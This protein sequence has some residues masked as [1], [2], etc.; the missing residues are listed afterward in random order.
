MDPISTPIKRFDFDDKISG[1]A[2]YCADIRS[3]NLLFAKT[4]RSTRPRA[5]ILS[6][7][8]PPLPDGYCIVDANDI[9]GRN[10][11]PIVQDDQPF[12]ASQR[13]NYIGEPI[14][15]VVGPDKQVIVDL[16]D[17]MSVTYED[18]RPVLSIDEAEQVRDD[19]LFGG[20]PCFVSYEFTKGDVA[21]AASQAERV[22]EDEFSTGYQEH[23][24]LETQGCC[25]VYENGRVTVSGSMQCPY[26]I[27]EAL[28]QALGWPEERVRV[29]QLPTGGGFGGKEEYPSIPAV[30]AALAAIKTNH[31]VQ[32][33]FDRHEDM[34]CTTKRHP[35]RIRIRS[36]VDGTKRVIGRE[37]TV[38]TDA[39]AYAGLSSVVLQRLMFSSGGVYDVPHL[40]VTGAAYATNNIVS[41]AFRGFGGPQAFFAMEMHMENIALGLGVDAFEFKC[42]HFL[43]RGD[44]SS[45]GGMFHYD[46]KLDDIAASIDRISGYG[47]KRLSRKAGETDKLRG[48]GCSFFFHGCGFTGSGEE[49]LIRARVRLKKYPD[50]SAGIFVSSTEIG[51]GALTTLRKI[52]AR[53]LEIPVASVRHSYPDSDECPNSGPT[54]ASRTV[55]IVGK[56]LHD[57]A[58]EIKSRWQEATC[59]VYREFEF[60][61]HMNW[62]NTTFRGNAY[63]EYSW[64]SNV[65]EVEVDPLTCSVRVLGVWAVYDI[66]TPIDDTIVRGQIEGGI[67]QGLAYGGMEQLWARN[68]E[69][70]QTSLR[71]YVIPT[72]LDYPRIEYRLIDNPFVNGPFGARGLGEL[73][74]IGAAPAL[75]L[76]VQN[77]IGHRVTRLPVTPEWIREMLDHAD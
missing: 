24:Y 75:A 47:R 28:V 34:L 17:R 20:N 50:N 36:Y 41:G 58:L 13:V 12:F 45:T 43:H 57:A 35:A 68:G 64:G 21:K 30:H 63:P 16:L 4:L 72:A 31:P 10:V 37:I 66:G 55:M 52:V 14:L 69:L 5:R 3:E 53:T 46:I 25:A 18:L 40:R 56:L 51:Q 32:L 22:F 44:R 29:I 70:G 54:V 61:G 42:R 77:A 49:Q 39:G 33:V 67:V 73:T 23:V 71:D 60:P 62:D 27:K 65:V 76:A 9:P 38:K 48:I 11:V 7:K 59:E 1:R 15:L 2:R 8:L 26:Y 6:L 19:D 74:L